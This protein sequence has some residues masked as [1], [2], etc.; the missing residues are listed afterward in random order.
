MGRGPLARA[1]VALAEPM[2]FH[3]RVAAGPQFPTVGELGYPDEV[4]VT[5]QAN[6][7]EAIRPGSETYVVIC[8]N[9]E[10]FS[11]PVLRSLLTNTKVPYVGMMASRAHAAQIFEDL[12][13][14]GFT[15]Q[16]LERVQCPLGLNI[17]SI[18]PEEIAVSALAQIV[19]FRRRGSRSREA[20]LPEA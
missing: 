20:G 9:D 16:E 18:T 19:A 4:I 6:L 15:D 14:V 8:A 13:N 3:I 1:L 11:Q 7:V 10:E 5:P 2:G 17:G 12:K